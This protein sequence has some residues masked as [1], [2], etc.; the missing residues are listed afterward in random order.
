[1]WILNSWW[2]HQMET[3]SMLLAFCAG[4]S[5][6]T[7]ELPTQRPVMR[8]FDAFFH[9]RL[10]KWL[11][12]K[13]WGWWFKMALCSLWRHCNVKGFSAIWSSIIHCNRNNIRMKCSSLAAL[14]LVTRP[15]LERRKTLGQIRS[16]NYLTW[17]SNLPTFEINMLNGTARNH[18]MAIPALACGVFFDEWEG[19]VFFNFFLHSKWNC[20]KWCLITK[21]EYHVHGMTTVRQGND[22]Q[23]YSL[24]L[25]FTFYL[26]RVTLVLVIFP[27][28]VFRQKKI[29]NQSVL[30]PWL[31][32]TWNCL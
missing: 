4:N 13:S 11:S 18:R 2:R 31:T 17:L 8:S 28:V 20:E 32:G 5:P 15:T 22:M 3:F 30:T 10:N 26:N 29:F 25:I 23:K 24:H 9:L 7:G 1:M 12:K 14:V 16:I 21:F 6:V 27:F 19:F